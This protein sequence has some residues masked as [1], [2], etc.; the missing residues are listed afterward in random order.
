[1]AERQCTDFR[2]RNVT[3]VQTL[4]T[5]AHPEGAND[6]RIYFGQVPAEVP[7]AFGIFRIAQFTFTFIKPDQKLPNVADQLVEDFRFVLFE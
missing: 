1:M 4:A 7:N 6:I 3:L 2:V 5:P